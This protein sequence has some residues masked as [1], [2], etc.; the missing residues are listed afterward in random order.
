[1]NNVPGPALSRLI[2]KVLIPGTD[3]NA[4]GAHTLVLEAM[5]ADEAPLGFMIGV[6]RTLIQ[7]EE[8]P[9]QVNGY[10]VGLYLAEAVRKYNEREEH[11]MTWAQFAKR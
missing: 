7:L 6:H 2:G 8:N 3:L 9:S 10:G 1:M 4:R 5:D 11:C